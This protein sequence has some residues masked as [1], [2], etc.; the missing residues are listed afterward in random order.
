MPDH[1]HMLLP[2]PHKYAVSKVVR[3]IEG[4]SAVPL[5][6]TCGEHRRKF[7]GQHFRARDYSVS[8]VGRDETAI[9]D[10][11]RNQVEDKC[12]DQLRMRK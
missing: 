1:V 8:S 2:M 11:I 7:A 3:Y 5:A 10:Y 6:R 9:R 4:R 12:P